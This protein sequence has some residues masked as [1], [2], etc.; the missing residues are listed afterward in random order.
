MKRFAVPA[1]ILATLA[2]A[3][4]F[5]YQRYAAPTRVATGTPSACD[6]ELEVVTYRAAL[7]HVSLRLERRCSTT[8]PHAV[9]VGAVSEC[10]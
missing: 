3:L 1:V 9:V 8:S 6:R 4:F 2:L 5:S 7:G 10:A